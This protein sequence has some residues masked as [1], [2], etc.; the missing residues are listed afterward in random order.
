M[1]EEKKNSDHNSDLDELHFIEPQ[2]IKLIDFKCKDDLILDIGGGGEGVI[3]KLK[4]KRVVSIDRQKRELEETDDESLKIVM[5]ATDLKFLD[6]SFYTVTSFF[7]LLYIPNKDKLNKIF[8]EIYRV[9]KPQGEFLIWDVIF[10]LPEKISKQQ[11]ALY[12]K[13][14][15]PDGTLVDTGY[16]TRMHAQNV[17]DFLELAKQHN[18]QVVEEDNWDK[19]F[20]IRL[21]KGE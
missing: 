3:G 15:M 18:F 9:L 8:S 12:L 7:T 16:G 21:K 11:I 4:G 17:S 10:E 5:D 20:F 13:V 2:R 14:D 1:P 19:V 6:R